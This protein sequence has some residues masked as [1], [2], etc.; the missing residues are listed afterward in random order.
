M[1]SWR[2]SNREGAQVQQKEPPTIKEIWL[3]KK[4]GNGWSFF[5]LFLPLDFSHV[6]QR[7]VYR[8]RRCLC[9][10]LPSNLSQLGDHRRACTR[11][12]NP[13][14]IVSWIVFSFSVLAAT[15]YWHW[16]SS[17]NRSLWLFVSPRLRGFSFS[18]AFQSWGVRLGPWTLRACGRREQGRE[19]LKVN[20]WDWSIKFS[21]WHS[22]NW[23]CTAFN[24]GHHTTGQRRTGQDRININ[25]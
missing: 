19:Q 14:V 11:R 9:R 12:P 17:S 22:P 10:L 13:P 3:Q 5:Y 18:L 8:R 25:N 2:V 20:L 23:T 7:P 6:Y 24:I 21:N 1:I 16:R 15:A 4:R